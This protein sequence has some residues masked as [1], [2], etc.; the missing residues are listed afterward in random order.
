VQRYSEV[1]KAFVFGQIL[2]KYMR[3][4]G[5]ESFAMPGRGKT[6]ERIKPKRA[7]TL[8]WGVTTSCKVYEFSSGR[9]PWR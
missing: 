4:G 9:I 1:Q 7:A 3:G 2:L 5:M 6:L 8:Q